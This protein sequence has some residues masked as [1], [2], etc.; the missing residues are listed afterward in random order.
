MSEIV[1][2]LIEKQELRKN[3]TKLLEQ[4][5][6]LP[7]TNW[8]NFEILHQ[9]TNLEEEKNTYKKIRKN[10]DHKGGVYVYEKDRVTLY[11]GR[12]SS[13]ERRIKRHH[14]ES[15]ADSS[16]FAKAQRL[17]FS[18]NKGRL[19]VYWREFEDEGSRRGVEGM[20]IF[21]LEPLFESFREEL[22]KGVAK[23]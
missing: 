14:H 17:F 3:I 18:K 13:L 20:L 22:K 21:A 9:K 16:H 2:W 12:G 4:H 15:Y 8:E 10:V 6:I 7:Y 5:R 19:R 1:D 23:Q 11:V